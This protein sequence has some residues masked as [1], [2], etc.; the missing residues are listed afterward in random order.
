MAATGD[1]VPSVFLENGRVAG[2]DPADPISVRY[3]QKIG[4]EP[5]GRDHPE[6]LIMGANNH[7]SDTITN[8]VSRIGCMSGGT[9]ARWKD[10]ELGA[11]FTAKA[12]EFIEANKGGPFFLYFAL[13]EP[14]VPRVPAPRFVG[15]TQLGPRGDAIA[16]IDNTCAPWLRLSRASS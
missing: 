12:V 2:L 8:G 16:Q 7:H 1:R 14:H 15:A 13:H 10:A 5:T 4:N 3:G 11:K 6:L 9:A